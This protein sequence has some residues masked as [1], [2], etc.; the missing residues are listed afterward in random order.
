[1]DAPTLILREH[2]MEKGP[3]ATPYVILQLF[4]SQT[5]IKCVLSA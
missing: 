1:M 4:T 2:F 5:D 3:E